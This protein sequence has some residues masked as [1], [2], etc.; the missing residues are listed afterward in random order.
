MT[1]ANGTPAQTEH[2]PSRKLRKRVTVAKG[3]RRDEMGWAVRACYKGRQ[4]E[5]RFKKD[6]TLDTVKAWRAEAIRQLKAGFIPEPH[7]MTRLKP[8]PEHFRRSVEGW[9]YI[10][11]IRDGDCIKI[12][13]AINPHSRLE[14][15]QTGH[16]NP[17]SLVA[18]IP[19][20][21]DLEPALHEL[22]EP[23]SVGHEWFMCTRELVEFI[24]RLN[25]GE[26]PVAVL[27]DYQ[28]GYCKRLIAHRSGFTRDPKLPEM[29]NASR[30]VHTA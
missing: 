26:N 6:Q 28:V 17:L 12:G 11:F 14:A 18:A 21:A 10:Y 13:R 1:T 16:K 20:H 5:R 29:L 25:T 9:C 24:E 23:I 30:T 15:L 3:I 19:A 27:W 7:H 8:T 22:F 2:Q 4:V